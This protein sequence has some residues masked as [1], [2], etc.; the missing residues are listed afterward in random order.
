MATHGTVRTPV[1]GALIGA[2]LGLVIITGARGQTGPLPG[3]GPETGADGSESARAI[4]FEE[5]RADK[6]GKRYPGTVMWR[7]DSNATLDRP[8]EIA[9]RADV[10]I[11]ERGMSMRFILQRN[12]DPALPASHTIEIAFTL[13][14][15]FSHG[16]VAQVPGVLMK[17]GENVRGAP[18][19]GVA[20]PMAPG[21]TLIGLSSVTADLQRNTELLGRGWIDVPIIYGDGLR[22]IIAIEKGA[23]GERA[24]A[25]AL[26]AG[27]GEQTT[28]SAGRY[29]DR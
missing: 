17:S 29:R 10:E 21:L 3:N 27:S 8:H 7:I 22:A 13:R 18:L 6:Y 26:A 5:D 1:L 28:R 20:V 2:A 24:V 16:G 15:E 25:Q 19:A 12:N 23:A 9:V 4:L 11:P 14:P